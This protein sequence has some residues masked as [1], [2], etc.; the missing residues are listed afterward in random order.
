[1]PPIPEPGTTYTY[2]RTFTAAD[3]AAFAAVSGDRQDRHTDPDEGPPMVHGLLTATLPT[4]I[5][6][7]LELLA[8]RMTFEFVAPVY[9]GEP[10]TCEATVVETEP[11]DGAGADLTIDVECRKGPDETVLRGEIEAVI[12]E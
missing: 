7:D 2:E 9:A 1:M 10:V 8:R 6:G 11:R 5:G 12:R 3:V 4:K